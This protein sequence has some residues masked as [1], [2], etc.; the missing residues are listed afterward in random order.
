M[1]FGSK[2]KT[3][4]I[5]VSGYNW[6]CEVKITDAFLRRCEASDINV[7]IFSS[8]MIKGDYP[9]GIEANKNLVRGEDEI[10]NLINYDLL[11][12][13]VLFRGSI[14]KES[15]VQKIASTCEEKNIPYISIHNHGGEFPHNVIIEDN[16]GLELLVEH[17]VRDHGLRRL[18]F[19]GGYP[20]N[21]ETIIR[22]EAYKKVLRKYNIPIEERRIEYGHFW[23]HSVDCAKKLLQIDT[24]DAF[25]C[26]N[27]TMA[28]MVSDYLK[29]EGY[30]IPSDLVVTGFDGTSDACTYSPSI[31]TIKVDFEKAGE[32]GFE[33][34]SKLMNGKVDVEDEH[35]YPELLIQESCGCQIGKKRDFNYIDSKYVERYLSETFNKNLIKTD[36]YFSDAESAD[37]LFGYLLSE[38]EFFKFDDICFCINKDF[39][40]EHKAFMYEESEKYGLSE[41]MN[42][43]YKDKKGKFV[44]TSFKTSELYPESFISASRTNEMT[45]S[46]LYHKSEF[47]GY[48]AYSPAKG[49]IFRDYFLLW[50]MNASNV[51][52]SFYSRKELERSSFQ[53]YMT[54]LYNRRGMSKIFA[55]SKKKIAAG[56]GYVSMFCADIDGLK[57][58]N[59]DYGHE[60]GDVAI[61]KI[62]DTLKEV[63]GDDVPCIR[64]GGDEFCI[65]LLSSH[66]PDTDR[67]IKNL[68][69]KLEAFNASS[70]LQFLLNCSCACS[71]VKYS[72]FVDFDTLRKASDIELYKVKDTHHSG[73][74]N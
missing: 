26:A 30:I 12:G 19:I 72:D 47:I 39:E 44:K 27:D 73:K 2:K 48:V 68:E 70:G 69:K 14:F 52:G 22:L 57:R 4:A 43:Y 56:K 34:L 42:A 38:V 60:A 58:I 46:P 71:T 41:E 67:Y 7:L 24:P 18:D 28:I 16:S 62:A 29:N 10:Y 63:F 53:D 65:L 15:T 59:D 1:H 50:M 45:F 64:T 11:D 17:L 51:I 49:E 23:K 33:L 9:K 20:D 31:T 35:V 21:R 61:I 6:E 36:V 8:L 32:Q 74:N 25:V 3:V 40:D 54:G 37:E 5:C 55:S 13:L 66:K